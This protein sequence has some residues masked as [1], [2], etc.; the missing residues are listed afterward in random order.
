MNLDIK[1]IDKLERKFLQ[2]S[3]NILNKKQVSKNDILK[4]N[5]IFEKTILATG[6]D[7]LTVYRTTEIILRG[8]GYN[9]N[10]TLE[11]NIEYMKQIILQEN[12]NTFKVVLIGIIS[13]LITAERLNKDGGE[14]KSE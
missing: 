14:L 1:K 12:N 7:L 5:K 9:L 8:T 2:K 4:I 6:A 11:E 13:K 3:I 10:S